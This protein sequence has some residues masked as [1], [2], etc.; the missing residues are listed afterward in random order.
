M[1]IIILLSALLFINTSFAQ[2]T[3]V[4]KAYGT[5]EFIELDHGLAEVVD[6]TVEKMKTSPTGSHGGLR[7]LE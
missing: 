7:I 1:K 2:T 6:G 4:S 5:L 3:V